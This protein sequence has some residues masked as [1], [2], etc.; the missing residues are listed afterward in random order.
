MCMFQLPSLTSKCPL[1][2]LSLYSLLHEALSSTWVFSAFL[3]SKYKFILK[4]FNFILIKFIVINHKIFFSLGE[5][6]T[7]GKAIIFGGFMFHHLL[8][9]FCKIQRIKK[10]PSEKCETSEYPQFSNFSRFIILKDDLRSC[11]WSKQA[12]EGE[13][14]Q[15]SSLVLSVT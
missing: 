4:W 10:L 3:K 12:Q 1:V 9:T 14:W 8:L 6:E 13:L 2:L 11:K 15:T 5:D 7:Q